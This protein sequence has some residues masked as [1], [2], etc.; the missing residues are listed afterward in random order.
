MSSRIEESA[1]NRIG[2]LSDKCIANFLVKSA[3]GLGVGVL[4]SVILFKRRTW[5][6]Q[7]FTGFGAGYAY[8]DCNRLFNPLAIPGL[9]IQKPE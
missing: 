2:N 5:P 6:I 1:E 7:L 9:K 8:S 4:T 3:T